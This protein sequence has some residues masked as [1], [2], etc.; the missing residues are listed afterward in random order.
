MV[1]EIII[2]ASTARLE[3]MNRST[4]HELTPAPDHRDRA[5]QAFVFHLKRR[6]GT[7]GARGLGQVASHRTGSDEPTLEE[8]AAA[9]SGSASFAAWSALNKGSQRRMWLALEDM[10]ER[11]LPELEARMAQISERPKRGSLALDPELPIPGHL[12]RHAFHGQPGGYVGSRHEADLRAGLLQEAGG[13]LYTRGVGTG[14]RDSK[15]QAVVRYLNERFPGLDPARILDLGCGYGGQ[16]CGYALAYPQAQTHGIDI[17]EGLLRYAHLRAESLGVPLHLHQADASGT[18]FPD[19]HFDLIV[20][21]ILLHEVPTPMM[22]AIMAE[23]WRLLAPGGVVIHQDV[24]TQDPDMPGF[25][26][27]L[28]MWQTE[29]NDEPFWAEFSQSSVPEA[30]IAAG[31]DAASVFEDYVAQ[32]D[33]PLTW[34]FVGAVR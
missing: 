11:Q 27:F 30:L 5:R 34:Y 26:R 9:M 3:D 21:N 19:G 15:A 8:T 4:V 17:G 20:S 31:F 18:G 25:A 7:L 23:C 16:T 6:L 10:V 12:R 24:P 29:H 32:V 14:R 33:G 22:R 28:S 1:Q 13:T 2:V